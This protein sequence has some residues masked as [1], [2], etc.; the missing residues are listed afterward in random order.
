MIKGG[1]PVVSDVTWRVGADERWVIIGPNGAGKSSLLDVVSARAHPTAGEVW[2]LGERLGLVD[3]FELRPRIGVV[4][5]ALAA[6]IPGRDSVLDVVLTA[7]WGMT[8]H[9]RERY[10]SVDAE[11]AGALL[12]QMGIGALGQRRYGTLSDGERKRALLARALMPDPELLVLDE[13]AA[14]L[15]LGAREGLITLLSELAADPAAPAIVL[16]THHVEE[17]P[18][19]FTHAMLL[20][21]GCVVAAGPVA[22]IIRGPQLSRAFGT[23]ITVGRFAGRYFAVAAAPGGAAGRP[24]P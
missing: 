2:L 13:P 16:V 1:S 5:T 22:E 24:A 17:V 11:R 10:D 4:G 18:P 19:Q 7:V 21:G 3:V 6:A 12:E 15:D 9:W 14:G 23:P 20:A 8:G